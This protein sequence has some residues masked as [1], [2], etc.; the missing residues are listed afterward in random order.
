MI[1][2]RTRCLALRLLL[3]LRLR[4]ERALRATYDRLVDLERNR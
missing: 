1:S 4:N 3:R 2:D